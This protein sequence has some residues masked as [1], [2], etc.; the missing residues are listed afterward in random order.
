MKLGIELDE[1]VTKNRNEQSNMAEAWISCTGN[2]INM[3]RNA[4]WSHILGML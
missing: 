1:E 4:G 3:L 2:I